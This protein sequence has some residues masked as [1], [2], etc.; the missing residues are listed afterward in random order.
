ML[1]SYL[2]AECFQK[3]LACY[4][5]RFA[6]SNARTEDLW[7]VLEEE[8]GEP[9]KMIMTS[10]TRQMGYPV[11]D[12]KFTGHDLQ[13]EQKAL[14]PDNFTVLDRAVIEHNLLSASKLYTNISL[15]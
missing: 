9:V 12:V 7:Q 2:G 11:I 3:A 14:L 1:Q 15:Y 10:W 13:F 5:K 6:C 4:I 8:S